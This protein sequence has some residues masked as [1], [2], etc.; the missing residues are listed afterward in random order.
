MLI[1]DLKN[2][3]HLEYFSPIDVTGAASATS[4]TDMINEALKERVCQDMIHII[5][6]YLLGVPIDILVDDIEEC[7][8]TGKFGNLKIVR[9]DNS[10]NIDGSFTETCLRNLN[11]HDIRVNSYEEGIYLIINSP[12]I[13]RVTTGNLP[14]RFSIPKF[15]KPRVYH[16]GVCYFM[17]FPSLSVRSKR[18][19]KKLIKKLGLENRRQLD[20]LCKNLLLLRTSRLGEN[21]LA[22]PSSSPGLEERRIWYNENYFSEI[23]KGKNDSQL[24]VDNQIDSGIIVTLDKFT[25]RKYIDEEARIFL[26]CHLSLPRQTF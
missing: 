23:N 14:L 15:L 26:R 4:L 1:D 22:F 25:L 10:V 5:L 13:F 6:S 19:A 3:R 9:V 7:L 2:Q 11:S 21:L 16:M 17:E 18:H 24:D 20:L 8:T 12:M